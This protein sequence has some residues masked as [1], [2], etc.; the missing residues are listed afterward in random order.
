VVYGCFYVFIGIGAFFGLGSH[1]QEQ[2]ALGLLVDLLIALFYGCMVLPYRKIT[3]AK[4]R[5]AVFV[6][7]IV[8]GLWVAYVSIHNLLPYFVTDT[9]WQAI[10]FLL[11]VIAIVLSNLWAYSTITRDAIGKKLVAP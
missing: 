2:P 8:Q 3:S 7:L 10:A 9:R 1:G 6:L 4:L 11:L 5:A